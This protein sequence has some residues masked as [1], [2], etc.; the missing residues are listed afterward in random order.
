MSYHYPYPRPSLAVDCVVFGFDDGDLKIFLIKRTE[1][2]WSL[3]GGVM[4]MDESLEEAAMR[5]LREVTGI[6]NLFIEQLFTFGRVDRDTR[7][8]VISVAYYALVN[9]TE[10]NLGDSAPKGAWYSQKDLPGLAYDHDEILEMGLRRLKGKLSYQPIG[11]ELLPEKFKLSQ[12]QHLYEVIL[13]QP[14]DKRNFRKK[15]LKMN[16][17]QE[18]DEV[19]QGVSH[20][21]A[22]LYR[23][24]NQRYKELEKQGFTFGI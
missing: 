16:V 5:K 17:L 12:L 22:R 3:P 4:Y 24:D 21:A 23:F 19:E 2:G 8:R 18:L 1:D 14:L 11:F 15:I 6:D 9:L 10:Q 7:E 20:R 13:D